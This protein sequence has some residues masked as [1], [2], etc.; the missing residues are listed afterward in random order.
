V[1]TAL[2]S[3]APRLVVGLLGAAWLTSCGAPQDGEAPPAPVSRRADPQPYVPPAADAPPESGHAVGVVAVGSSLDVVAAALRVVQAIIDEDIE[4]VMG[5][6][7]D[8]LAIGTT[9]RS[10]PRRMLHRHF[11]SQF[12]LL[13]YHQFTLEEV[14]DRDRIDVVPFESH[15]SA[16]RSGGTLREGDVLVRLNMLVTSRNRRRYFEDVYEWWFRQVGGR[17]RIVAWGR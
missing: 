11:D 17:W 16:G 5:V 10:V 4:G 14:V 15:G 12:A 13:D 2:P 8:D 9:G 6:V 1:T 7:A 3:L